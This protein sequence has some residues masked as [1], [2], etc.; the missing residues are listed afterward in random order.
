VATAQAQAREFPVLRTATTPENLGEQNFMKGEAMGMRA[1]IALPATIIESA[2]S[3]LNPE[4]KDEGNE[5][6][7]A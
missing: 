7:P 3:V 4:D 5:N 1:L 6:Q 2:D